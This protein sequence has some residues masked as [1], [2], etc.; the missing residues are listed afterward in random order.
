M[1]W[2][3]APDS[4]IRHPLSLSSFRR[5]SLGRAYREA[6][7][8]QPEPLLRFQV[9]GDWARWKQVFPLF[10]GRRGPGME[11]WERAVTIVVLHQWAAN[12][13]PLIS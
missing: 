5:P 7:S 10:V 6:A 12:S 8:Q 9:L 2:Q 3:I 11:A 13:E 4:S 1:F